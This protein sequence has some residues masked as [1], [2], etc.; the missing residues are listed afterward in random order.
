MSLGK[1]DIP[2]W[3]ALALAIG[4]FCRQIYSER[5]QKFEISRSNDLA[6]VENL[7]GKLDEIE[8]QAFF[9]WT[10]PPNNDA[11]YGLLLSSA[12][13]S[14]SYLIYNAPSKFK[15]PL[16]PHVMPLRMAITGGQFRDA[17]RTALNSDHLRV[18]SMVL[19]IDRTRRTLLD[20]KN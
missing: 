2:A 8:R 9:Y 12:I 16:S 6:F 4:T 10:T 11:Y 19:E 13:K 15:K 5:K 14:F 1:G 17:N 3:L 20:C 18:K 7:S